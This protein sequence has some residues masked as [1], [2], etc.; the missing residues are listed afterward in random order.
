MGRP[1]SA[2]GSTAGRREASP[3]PYTH[4]VPSAHRCPDIP[5]PSP[6]S[7]F[8]HSPW[9]WCEARTGHR[10]AAGGQPIC[11]SC[12]E[13][14]F[15]PCSLLPVIA[16]PLPVLLPWGTQPLL[17]NAPL[18]A[19]HFHPSA[20]Q[21]GLS[22]PFRPSTGFRGAAGHGTG[23]LVC[24]PRPPPTELPPP[25]LAPA[26][27]PRRWLASQRRVRFLTGGTT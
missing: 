14:C 10:P 23:H 12:S 19:C 24:C 6:A 18:P 3:P 16:A 5:I 27:G 21:T 1:C 7:S 11:F 2:G 9:S 25:L 22:T 26:F 15:F 20:A 8:P 13:P 4:P 17:Q